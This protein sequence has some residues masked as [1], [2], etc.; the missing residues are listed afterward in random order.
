MTMLI[1]RPERLALA[2]ALAVSCVSPQ[3]LSGNLTLLNK[4]NGACGFDTPEAGSGLTY[5]YAVDSPSYACFPEGVRKIRFSNL[6]SAME[7]ILTSNRDCSPELAGQDDY[8]VRLKT[9]ASN[10]GDE[11]IYSFEELQAFTENKTI[12]RGLKVIDKKAVAADIMRDATT[13]IAISASPDI[14]TPAPRDALSVSNHQETPKEPERGGPD[15]RAC[16]SNSFMTARYHHGDENKNTHYTC[17]AVTGYTTQSPQW[18]PEFRESGLDK[19]EDTQL[20]ANDKR[21]IYFTCPVDTVMTAR[22][23][24]GDENGSTKYQCARLVSP[25]GQAVIVEPGTWSDELTESSK[26]YE[27]CG[28][29]QAMIGRAHK[30]DENGETRFL[31]ATLRPLA[32]KGAN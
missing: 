28:S 22:W 31:C 32:A 21:Y 13:C 24:E 9:I 25:Q 8:W 4:N 14:D 19:L 2:I 6:P 15:E 12:F 29:N 20:T 17:A 1:Y 30:N 11:R 23:H 27:V 7:I 3:A 18:S 10:T 26:T 5:R 16:P